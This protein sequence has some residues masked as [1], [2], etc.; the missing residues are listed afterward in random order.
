[1]SSNIH[2]PDVVEAT[3]DRGAFSGERV[4][5]LRDAEDREHLLGIP[6]HYCYDASGRHVSPE[7]AYPVRGL[8]V[9]R[10]CREADH[11]GERLIELADSTCMVVR[12]DTIKPLFRVEVVPNP[13]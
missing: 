3:I 5:T 10:D 8:V 13:Q 1:M 9:V 6:A 11:E 4:V 2:I 12:A 7:T